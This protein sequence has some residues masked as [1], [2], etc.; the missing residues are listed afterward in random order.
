MKVLQLCHKPPCPPIDG[1]T[2][3]MHCITEGLIDRGHEVKIICIHTHKHPLKMELLSK[4][5]IDATKIEGV[6]VDTRVNPVEAFASLITQDSY[7]ISRFFSPD[8]DIKLAKLLKRNKFD[9]I[10]IESLFMTPYLETIRRYSKAKVVM[11]SHNIEHLIWEKQAK[12]TKNI[13]RKAYLKYLASK[14]KEYELSMLTQV[15]GIVAIS[16]IDFN[17]FRKLGFKRAMT[18]V[19]FGIGKIEKIK[20]I[21]DRELAVCYLGSMEWSPNLEGMIWFLEE[22][23]PQVVIKH[24]NLKFYLAGRCIPRDMYDY[25]NDNIKIVGEVPDVQEFLQQYSIMV[26]PLLSAGGIRVRI[27]EGMAAGNAI[28]STQAAAAGIDYKDGQELL[29]ANTA[30]QFVSNIGTLLKDEELRLQLGEKGISKAKEKYDNYLVIND[31]IAF[32]ESLND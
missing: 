9:V 29:I 13:A 12:A 14:L 4:E 18:I 5:Y 26:V 7:N 24:P 23:W 6:F 8:F 17:V 28:V 31:L 27:I 30:A 15:D 2:R 19:P 25:E 32:Y 10:H 1:G 20:A 21:K 11:R 22:V 3:S 16:P